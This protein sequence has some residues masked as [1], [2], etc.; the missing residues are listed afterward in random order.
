MHTEYPL[1]NNHKRLRSS[2]RKERPTL[3]YVNTTDDAYKDW[4][5]YRIETEKGVLLVY[6]KGL[7]RIV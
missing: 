3:E 1:L 7:G 2:D 6:S 5:F 4:I